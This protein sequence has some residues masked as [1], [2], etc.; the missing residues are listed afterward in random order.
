LSTSAIIAV[1]F[2]AAIVIAVGVF[3]MRDRVI[4]RRITESAAR[5]LS[6]K[7]HGKLTHLDGQWRIDAAYEGRPVVLVLGGKF[8]VRGDM[9]SGPDFVPTLDIKTPCATTAQFCIHYNFLPGTAGSTHNLW[10]KVRGSKITTG[11]GDFDS[12]FLVEGPVPSDASVLDEQIRERM[13]LSQSAVHG[14]SLAGHSWLLRV[15][16]GLVEGREVFNEGDQAVLAT[17][18]VSETL[19]RIDL[20][21]AL[22]V[23]AEQRKPGG[24]RTMP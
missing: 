18:I 24:T 9:D 14:H 22:A 19:S 20:L 8:V 2:W 15:G 21:C 6:I 16:D 23:S 5:S 17:E 11:A 10:S 13:L 4:Q 1:L 3:W 12:R 7:L